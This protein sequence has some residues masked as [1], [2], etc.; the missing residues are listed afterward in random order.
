MSAVVP[1]AAAV[2]MGETVAPA[3]PPDK[4]L[5]RHAAVAVMSSAVAMTA[6]AVQ[7]ARRGLGLV[8]YQRDERCGGES[9][10]G[11]AHGQSWCDAHLPF[12]LRY[13]GPPRDPH[14]ASATVD[15]KTLRTI[16]AAT[17]EAAA[18]MAVSAR[19]VTCWRSIAFLPF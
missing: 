18:L 4:V 8:R 7:R 12:A 11:G 2:L 5:A 9:Q 6:V 15:A 10:N 17:A 14:R 3:S 13:P 1:P 19:V 16:M